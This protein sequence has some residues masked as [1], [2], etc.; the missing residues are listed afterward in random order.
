MKLIQ[1]QLLIYQTRQ[2]S[3]SDDRCQDMEFDVDDWV[4]LKVS[5]M[6]G[7]MRFDKK[8]KLIPQ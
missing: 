4:F 2:K 3:Y 5:L 8:G 6:K 1:D 7:I